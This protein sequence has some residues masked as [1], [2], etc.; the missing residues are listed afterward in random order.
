MA[1]FFGTNGIRGIFDQDLS[2]EFV[3]YMT[4][5]IGTFFGKGPILVGYDGRHSSP[6]L[7]KLVTSALNSVGTDSSIAGLIPTPCLEY[8]VRELGYTGGIMITASHNPPEYN[9]LKLVASDGVE[10][11][12]DDE[13]AIESIYDN[14]S[15]T[16]S[17]TWGTTSNEPRAIQTYLDGILK[18]LDHKSITSK[19]FRVV[20]DLGNGTQAVTAPKLCEMLGCNVHVINDKIDGSFEGRGSEPKPD[21]LK[22]LS[23]TVTR[24]LADFGIAFDGDGDR[25]MFCDNTGTILTGDKSALVLVQHILQKSSGGTIVTGLNSSSSIENISHRYCSRVIRTKVGSVEI[26]RTMTTNNALI[27]FEENGGFIY[28]PHNYVRDGCMTLGLVLE[29]LSNT[30]KSLSEITYDLPVSFT[31]KDKIQCNSSLVPK[32]FDVLKEEYSDADTTDGIKITLDSNTWVMIRPSGTE[33]ILRVY[34]EAATRDALD[35]LITKY[36]AKVRSIIT[37][38]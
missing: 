16:R 14:K 20:L 9:G 24:T 29:L 25:S 31:T 22:E 32:V 8:A 3:H 6:L 15:W 35:S 19:K 1:K 38:Y 36:T 4:L 13:N 21:N 34:A 7:T 5:A 18:C 17:T 28:G 10:I 30:D 26:S 33:P 27:G 2:L 37:T 12:R 23:N 11:S